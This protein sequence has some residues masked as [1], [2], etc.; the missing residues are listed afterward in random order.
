[1]SVKLLRKIEFLKFDFKGVYFG[2]Y[3]LLTQFTHVSRHPTQMSIKRY[4]D[5]LTMTPA[6]EIEEEKLEF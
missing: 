1:M 6:R 5:V 4:F 2:R 3:A